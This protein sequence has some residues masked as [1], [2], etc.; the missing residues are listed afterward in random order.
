[1]IWRLGI[2]R[3]DC[4]HRITKSPDRRIRESFGPVA[5]ICAGGAAAVMI[6]A[7]PT[8]FGCH[9]AA[10]VDVA[11]SRVSFG[12]VAVEF[13]VGFFFR[14]VTALDVVLCRR[15]GVDIAEKLMCLIECF[16]LVC[17]VS[18]SLVLPHHSYAKRRRP[19]AGG[20]RP[21]EADRS[22]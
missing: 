13:L 20:D 21:A 4:R 6:V 2:W 11:R 14:S 10:L 22:G 19:T 16:S 5:E 12:I 8:H 9:A 15:G 3:S 1:M 7:C 17:H 18:S